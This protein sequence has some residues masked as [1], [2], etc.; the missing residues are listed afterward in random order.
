MAILDPGVV[1]PVRPH[2]ASWMPTGLIPNGERTHG[3][4][5]RTPPRF[6]GA[7]V[8]QLAHQIVRRHQFQPSGLGLQFLRSGMSSQVYNDYFAAYSTPHD[9]Y[10]YDNLLVQRHVHAAGPDANGSSL[11]VG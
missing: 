3:D 11:L 8:P 4:R 6:G 7:S 10:T 5:L 9:L 1:T 2:A